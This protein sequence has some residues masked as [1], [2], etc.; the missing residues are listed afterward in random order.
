MDTFRASYAFGQYS[1]EIA[2][3]ADDLG[4]FDAIVPK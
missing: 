2:V 4:F 3:S 1:I